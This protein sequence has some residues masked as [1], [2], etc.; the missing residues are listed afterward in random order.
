M[1][2][3]NTLLIKT[4]EGVVFSQ[5]LAGPIARFLAWLID[6]FCLWILLLV[7]SVT[8]FFLQA[9]TPDIGQAIQV[10]AWFIISVGYA[11]AL[12]WKWRGQ[13][14]GKKFMRLRVVDAQGLRLQFSQVAIRNLLRIIDLLPLLYVVGGA[15]TLLTRKAQRLGDLAA[16]TVVIRIPRI[17][18][19]N[20]EQLG[21]DKFNS[22]R[23]HPHLCARL[24]QRVTPGEASVALQAMTRRNE[25]EP[26]ARVQL[27]AELAE[28]FRTKVSFPPEAVEGIT[29]EQY[30]RNVVDVL[31]RMETK[32]VPRILPDHSEE[33]PERPV[34]I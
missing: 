14:V 12:E 23:S 25:L 24:R 32:R 20:L 19:P 15:A 22:L 31:Y 17:S 2:R 11:M 7:L 5:T 29:D 4:P 16:N 6:L 33:S 3:T 21:A 18:E 27:F 34:S 30:V 26:L 1:T 9:V 10:I 8:L 28:H 13:T